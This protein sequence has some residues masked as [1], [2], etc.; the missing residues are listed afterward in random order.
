MPVTS[1]EKR[2]KSQSTWLV[3]GHETSNFLLVRSHKMSSR[4]DQLRNRFLACSTTIGASLLLPDGEKEVSVHPSFLDST[5]AHPEHAGNVDSLLMKC[6]LDAGRAVLLQR[7][8]RLV[9]T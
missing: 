2:T 6:G 8:T 4:V 7:M 3:S 9:D 1:T 5:G